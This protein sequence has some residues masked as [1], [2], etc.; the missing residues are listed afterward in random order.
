[1]SNESLPLLHTV[2]GCDEASVREFL[3]VVNY[4]SATTESRTVKLL[5]S[6]LAN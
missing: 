1:M 3:L 4:L 6:E 2:R 5:A